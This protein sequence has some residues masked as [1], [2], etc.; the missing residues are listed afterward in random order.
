MRAASI[1]VLACEADALA[2]EL[3]VAREI[4]TDRQAR[5]V[6]LGRIL[7][8]AV[9][10]WVPAINVGLQGERQYARGMHPEDHA[11]RKLRAYFEALGRNPD[12]G[13]DDVS[14][15]ELPPLPPIPPPPGTV[16]FVAS[17]GVPPP[18][19]A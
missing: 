4:V 2:I 11:L 16:F 6:A 5:L 19:A 1:Q 12:L 8:G 18:R 9:P 3:Q 15:S 14:D 10:S 17:T 13:W 7:V